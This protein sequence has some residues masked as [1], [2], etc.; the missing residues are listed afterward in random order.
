MPK[1]RKKY[2]KV[3]QLN[4]VAD[5]LLKDILICYVDELEG[6]VMLDKK[7]QQIIRPSEA[8]MRVETRC[9]T[10]YPNYT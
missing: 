8:M 10:S 4:R 5:H 3:K 6:C 1:I 2:N 7:R 9:L